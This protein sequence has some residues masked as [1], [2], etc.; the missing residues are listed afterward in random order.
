M[1]QALLALTPKV[2][3]PS[4]NIWSVFKAWFPYF[5]AK[6]LFAEGEKTVRAKR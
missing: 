1:F 5:D 2:V 3:A 4:A 6:V